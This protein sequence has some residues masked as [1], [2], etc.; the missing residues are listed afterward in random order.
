[1]SN[2]ETVEEEGFTIKK[3]VPKTKKVSK[4]TAIFVRLKKRLINQ[5]PK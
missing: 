5:L 1:M 2:T 4:I 3:F